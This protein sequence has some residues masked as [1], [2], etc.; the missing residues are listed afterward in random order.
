[1]KLQHWWTAVAIV[2]VMVVRVRGA[3][4]A[5]STVVARHGVVVSVSRAGSEVGCE[6][7]KAGGNAVDA[8]VATAF[9]LAVA[10]PEAGNIGGGGFMLV[11]PVG[12]E[13]PTFFDYRETAPAA[14]TADMY[15]RGK[16]NGYTMVGVPGTVRGLALAHQRFGRLP[17]KQ[18]VGPAVRLAREGV[19]VDA[20]LARSLNSGLRGAGEFAEFRRVFGKADGSAWREGDRLVQPE[21]ARTLEGIADRG[22]DAFYRGEVSRQIAE[23]VRAGGGII[24]E[25]DL[26]KYE[27]KE[28][29]P[30]RGTY[31]GY[32]VFAA[33]P[34]S[35]G[36]VA[37]IEMLNVLEGFPLHEWG[38]FDPRTLH[39]MTEAMR[40][41]YCDRAEYLGDPDFAAVPEK[42]M[43][44][45][46][47][48]K[49]AKGIDLSKAGSSKELA[50]RSG[51]TISEG[52][53]QTTHFC[54]IDGQGMAVSNTFTLE[55]SF[56]GRIV[57]KGA[58]FLLNNEMGDFN[59]RPGVTTET[60]LIGTTPNRAAAG[61]RMLSSMTPTIVTKDGRVVLLT[62]SPGGRTIINTVLCVT[63]NVLEFGMP[64]RE[65]VDAPRIH[66]AW[67][68]DEL[69]VE[70]GLMGGHA[71][72]IEQLRKM[73]HVVN[74]RAP[75]Q[76]D[77]HSIW[78]DPASGQYTGAADGR[79]GGAAVGY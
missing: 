71:E 57:V 6:T 19:V 65:A 72:A 18:V 59:P 9:A 78:V 44:K 51:I 16:R 38:R 75:R 76:G 28:R 22:A 37:L 73:G 48:K 31:R 53:P 23:T 11:R 1:M 70:P 20:P 56:G 43:D 39:V 61:K 58:G 13:E 30:V 5:G 52:G 40:F 47:A 34:P 32:E 12:A 15:V 8:A 55:E 74:P 24:T 68:P 29:K 46:F 4:V 27:A 50:G 79:I 21:L 36:G 35:S 26:A 7:L 69:T 25:A 66:H 33:A 77:A 2:C 17:W 54:V 62:G 10:W 41:A 67:F 60:G 45:A 49:R 14:S 63:L 3:E 42:L 64:V